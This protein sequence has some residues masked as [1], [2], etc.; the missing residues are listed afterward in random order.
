MTSVEVGSPADLIEL[1]RST[2]PAR[3]APVGFSSQPCEAYLCAV[4]KN[5]ISF[6]YV[7]LFLTESN[8]VLV[9]VSD[10]P[11]ADP[12]VSS[13]AVREAFD[14][15]ESIGF[16]LEKVA[17]G[18]DPTQREKLVRG[19]PVLR[20][21]IPTPTA[22][23]LAAQPQFEPSADSSSWQGN[24][25]T[26]APLPSWLDN[27]FPQASPPPPSQ[28]SEP[29][30][31][32]QLNG[33]LA[34]IEV[35]AAEDVN[36]LYRSTAAVR[37]APA[38]FHAQPVEAYICL[39]SGGGTAIFVALFL[40]ESRKAL[41]YNPAQ[42]PANYAECGKM[43]KQAVKFVENFG[44]SME[45][46]NLG[47]NVA[48]RQ[49][50]LRSIPVLRLP[51]SRPLQPMTKAPATELPL[52]IPAPA[53][54]SPAAG[55]GSSAGKPAAV[56]VVEPFPLQEQFAVRQDPFFNEPQ[57]GVAAEISPFQE[58]RGGEFND[59]FP[60][61][62]A[63]APV[64]FS[65]D[66]S[67]PFIEAAPA[68]IV[69]LYSSLGSK[70]IAPEGATAEPC[71][72]YIF[73]IKEGAATNVYVALYLALSGK[74]L[75][76][77]PEKQP[78]DQASYGTTIGD[79]VVF[80]ESLGFMMD[81]AELGGT[82]ENRKAA[83]SRVKVLRLAGA[84]AIPDAGPEPTAAQEAPAASFIGFHSAEPEGAR[85]QF[86]LDK[87]RSFIEAATAAEIKEAYRSLTPAR[88]A[89]EGVNSEPCDACICAVASGGQTLVYL[90]LFLTE[91][92]KAMVYTPLIQPQD[93][94]GYAQTI[95]AATEFL[96]SIGFMLERVDLGANS[97]QRLAALGDLRALRLAD[98]VKPLPVRQVSPT[99]A[100]QAKEPEPA[101]LTIA[102]PPTAPSPPPVHNEN[103]QS[104][105]DATSIPEQLGRIMASF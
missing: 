67:R 43:F 28:P 14:F 55:P 70:H 80:L 84:G 83:L 99:V 30:Q 27:G 34:G 52:P 32:F 12:V 66:K 48:L 62:P 87:S 20:L 91:S 88:I 6:V 63:G 18:T 21:T 41:V 40:T 56:E 49:V 35:A 8:K 54:T 38:G 74:G 26:S 86:G 65:L 47:S 19:L 69:E 94:A 45:A 10:K 29:T 2:T 50:V 101:P 53:V 93:Q 16:V 104:D 89:P 9:Y 1:Y 31:L 105:P 68:E 37:L 33:A 57:L 58:Q 36:E 7:T 103:R 11:S 46:V 22:P 25:F 44:F 61:A 3:I 42:Q 92:D 79:A 59:Y 96:E 76:Y 51:G 75:V 13:R 73:A 98:A 81:R 4:N 17:L 64:Q 90:A 5:G 71:D 72:A 85:V 97:V 24:G 100:P 78:Q 102:A 95:L 82:A 15:A 39:V 23:P 77:L 60:A